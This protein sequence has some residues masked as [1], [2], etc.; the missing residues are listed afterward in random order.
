MREGG[1][2]AEVGPASSGPAAGSPSS[3]GGARAPAAARAFP[4]RGDLRRRPP[5]RLMGTE[6]RGPPPPPA[7]LQASVQ[8]NVGCSRLGCS[9]GH[10]TP[11]TP[12]GCARGGRLF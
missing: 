4:L 10:P 6:L 1:E 12:P 3:C 5:S 9:G 11:P 8:R 7:P 2:W